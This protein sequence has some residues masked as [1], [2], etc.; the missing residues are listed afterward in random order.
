MNRLRLWWMR[1]AFNFFPCYRRTGARIAYIAPDM[2]LVRIR[3]PLNWTT[4]G[5][6]GTTFGGSLYGAVDPVYLVMLARNLGR[7]YMIWDKSARIEFKKPGRG[8]LYATFVLTEAELTAI[9]DALAVEPKI[10]RTYLVDLVDSAGTVHATVEKVV[11]IR[12]RDA[13]KNSDK[14]AA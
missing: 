3:L 10:D 14:I 13:A 11:N 5:Y 1:T 7:A 4:R 2:K 8:T 9:R 12:R 6:W